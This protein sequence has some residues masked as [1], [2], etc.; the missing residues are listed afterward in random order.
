MQVYT[1]VSYYDFK[2]YKIFASIKWII[3]SITSHNYNLFLE[4]L[5]QRRFQL[6]LQ[7]S[8]F[9]SYST[10]DKQGLSLLQRKI[11]NFYHQ[12]HIFLIQ[13]TSFPWILQIFVII[14]TYDTMYDLSVWFILIYLM[15]CIFI[16][17]YYISYGFLLLGEPIMILHICSFIQ[18]SI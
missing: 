1:E 18:F 11:V 9:F 4:A 17:C 2:H 13:K 14:H 12:F 5:V 8:F 10:L 7:H 6:S 3:I 16:I 15:L